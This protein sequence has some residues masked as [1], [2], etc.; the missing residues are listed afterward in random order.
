VPEPYRTLEDVPMEPLVGTPEIPYETAM[1]GFEVLLKCVMAGS[2]GNLVVMA[3]AADVANQIL[4]E[5]ERP[6]E[7]HPDGALA[8]LQMA[9]WGVAALVS[10]RRRTMRLRAESGMQEPEVPC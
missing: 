7:E 10:E 3:H 9:C 1:A 5:L 2:T 6:D 8:G 4:D